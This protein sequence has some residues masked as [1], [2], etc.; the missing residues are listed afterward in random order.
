MRLIQKY[1]RRL[2]KGLYGSRLRQR[3][4]LRQNG[5]RRTNT[6]SDGVETWT[7]NSKN[8]IRREDSNKRKT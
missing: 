5:L 6:D 8:E 3:R 4:Y 1:R 7:L 2:L